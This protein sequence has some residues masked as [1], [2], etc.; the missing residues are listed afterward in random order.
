V[1]WVVNHVRP[2]SD[3][4]VADRGLYV[5]ALT[6]AVAAGAGFTAV[7][8]RPMRPRTAVL[9]AGGV[10]GATVV[11]WALVRSSGHLVAPAGVQHRALLLA[12]G[13]LAAG[14]ALLVALGRVPSGAALVAA[15]ALVAGSL[16]GLANF[17]AIL[18]PDQAYPAKP[19]SIAALQRQPGAFRVGVIRHPGALSVLNPNAAALFG[20]DGIEGYDFPLSKRWSDLQTKVLRFP[21]LRAES[22]KAIGVPSGPALTA[23]RMMNTR[24]YVAGPGERPPSP[25]FRAVYSGP[26]ATVLRDDAALPRAYVVAAALRLPYRQALDR[27]VRGDLDPRR[28]ALVPP[29]APSLAERSAS[30][31]DLQPARVERLA[32]D[33]VRVHLARGSTGWL[34]LADAYAPAWKAEV[35]G[36]SARLWPTDV[37]A[38]GLPVTGRSRTVDFRL[39]RTSFWLGAGISL[40]G[41]A[42]IALLV[43][44][45]LRRR[46]RVPVG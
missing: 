41:L 12:A 29:G 22:A 11:A 33:H 16:A 17:N 36:R 39:D 44:V 20:L 42:A 18:P 3:V 13:W 1:S 4:T 23:Y 31:A 46:R 43:A 7:S 45:G 25:G 40:A 6:A 38:M 30:G 2:W 9:L 24:F 37:V 26:D 8:R 27:L 5:I 34:V 32:P 19:A 21:T 10:L 14:G 15:L 28:L 35:D